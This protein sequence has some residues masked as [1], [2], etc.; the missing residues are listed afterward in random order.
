MTSVAY[1]SLRSNVLTGPLPN[2]LEFLTNMIQFRV[3]DNDLSGTIP[4]GIRTWEGIRI[5]DTVGNDKLGGSIPVELCNYRYDQ[6]DFEVNCEQV[7][8]CGQWFH[9]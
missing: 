4:R 9:R 8:C 5:F 7:V 1:L 2:E 3:S 6:V